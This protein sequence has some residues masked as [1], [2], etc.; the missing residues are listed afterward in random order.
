VIAWKRSPTLAIHDRGSTWTAVGHPSVRGFESSPADWKETK[1]GG[2]LTIQ[3]SELAKLGHMISAMAVRPL[4]RA[5]GSDPATRRAVDAFASL[6]DWLCGGVSCGDV[7]SEMW[8]NPVAS[9]KGGSDTVCG[10]TLL[11]GLSESSVTSTQSPY[12]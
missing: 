11:P 12:L 3:R 7:W 2:C 1:M 6:V 4:L 8:R 10:D 9:W 5:N